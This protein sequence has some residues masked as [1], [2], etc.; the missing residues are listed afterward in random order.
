MAFVIADPCI[1]VCDAACVQ[2]CPVDCI[3]GP[4]PGEPTRQLF[5]DADQCIC[6]AQCEPVCPVNA[7]FDESALPEQWAAAL[8]RRDRFFETF[9]R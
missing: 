1:A 3:H 8:K 7:I 6:C 9:R 2:V 5:I 4:P